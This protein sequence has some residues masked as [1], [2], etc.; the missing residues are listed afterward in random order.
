[1]LINPTGTTPTTTT[2]TAT[3]GV[4]TGSKDEF[5][6]LFM[7]QLEHQ[8]PLNPQSGA[9][10]VAQLAQFSSVEQATQTNQRLADLASAQ[11]ATSSA[12]LA[13]L[14]GRD[15]NAAAADFQLDRGG[16]PGLQIPGLQI[17][18]TTAMTGASVVI[19]DGDGKELRRIAVP[20][21]ASSAQIAWDGNDASGAPVRPG[22]Y[23]ITVEPGTTS[24]TIASQWRGRVD[25][26]ELGASGTRLRMGGVL[27]TPGDIQT[28]GQLSPLST[29]SL[30]NLGATQ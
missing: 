16:A 12:G 7:A 18:S 29:Q 21:G 30:S 2:P 8:D 1:M 23:H 6:K 13:S 28:I 19:S 3:G 11:A 25:A 15:C 27:L 20:A 4:L 9:D 24:G 14:V 10:M 17:T 26:V 22:S 5:L